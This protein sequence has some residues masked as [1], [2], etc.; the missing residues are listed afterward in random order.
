MQDQVAGASGYQSLIKQI[1]GKVVLARLVA[2]IHQFHKRMRVF[3]GIQYN[4]TRVQK[5]TG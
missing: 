2:D 1:A 4:K 5:L 3:L